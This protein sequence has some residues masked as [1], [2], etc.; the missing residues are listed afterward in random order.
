MRK[1][2]SIA[3][4]MALVA[5]TAIAG[6]TLWGL[7]PHEQ[8][9]H[10][11]FCFA[12]WCIAPAG[13][14][15]EDASTVV[16]AVARSEARGLTQRPDYPQAWLADAS[17]RETGGPQPELNRAFGPGASFDVDLTFPVTTTGCLTFVVGE[18][19]WPPFLGLGYSPSPFTERASWRLCP[20]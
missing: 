12:E 20:R 11:E 10:A 14:H 3:I 7:Q 19:A 2:V 6:F 16:H 1:A 8:P 15:V 17:G 13:L 18:G 4:G 5:V 9:G